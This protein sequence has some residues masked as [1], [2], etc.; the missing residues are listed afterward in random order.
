MSNTLTSRFFAVKTTGGQEKNVAKSVGIRLD[1]KK[2]NNDILTH[3]GIYS[4][5]VIEALKGYVFFEAPNAQIVGDAISGFKHVKNLIPGIVKYEDIQKFLITRSIISE[6]SINDTV[7]VTSGP[8]KNSKAKITR[9]EK[10]RAEATIMLL[11]ATYQLPV[12]VDVDHLKI[13]E[14]SQSDV[15]A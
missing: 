12:T 11:D 6:L 9:L 2:Q 3:S 14:K 5:I 10:S 1:N 4:I 8:F 7:E 13:I 15:N